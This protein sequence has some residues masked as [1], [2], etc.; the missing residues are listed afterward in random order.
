M[1]GF[2][3]VCSLMI[4]LLNVIY[5]LPPPS[6]EGGS[7]LAVV[8]DVTGSMYDDLQQVVEG[9]SRILEKTLSSRE[10]AIHNLALVPFHDPEVGPVM[11]T[12][13]PKEFQKEL[14]ELYVQ[15]GGD[16]P[17]MSITAIKLAMEVS[18]P[19]SFIYVFTDA[20][21]KDYKLT[22]DVLQ[23][24]Q[25]KQSQVVFVLTG[26]CG[27]RTHAGYKAY[28]EIAA[29]SSGQIFHL[30]KQQVDE[31][32]KWVEQAVQ[33]SKVHLL[34]TDHE[35]GGEH[36][37]KVPF[38]PSLKEVTISLSGL[39]P[40]IEV[41]DPSGQ[42]VLTGQG[43]NN[44]LDLPNSAKVVN[45]KKPM[46]GLW[47]IKLKSSGRHS[48]RITGVSSLDFR[49]G[50]ATKDTTDFSKTSRRPVQGA[51]VF[52]L[53]NCTGLKPPGQIQLVEFISTSGQSLKSMSVNSSSLTTSSH[54]WS[55]S[56][57][58]PPRENFFLKV[59]GND[60]LGYAF[61]RLSSVSYS[62]ISPRPP[63]VTMPRKIQGFYL[64][65]LTVFCS[66]DSDIAYTLRIL[67][68]GKRLEQDRI[69]D[70]S[71]NATWEIPEAA[72]VDEGLYECVAVSSAGTGQAYTYVAITE[73]P[74]SMGP[75]QNITAL[76]HERIILSCPVR[77]TVRY[78]MTWLHEGKELPANSERVRVS[79]DLSLEIIRVQPQD[80]GQYVCIASNHHGSSRSSIWL[81]I[82]EAPR[83]FVSPIS[84]SFV[85]GADVT[86]TCSA[87]GYPVPQI[88]W[89]FENAFFLRSYRHPV[90]EQGTL[91]I[92]NAAKEDAGRYTCIASNSG[93]ADRQSSTL[94]YTEPPVITVAKQNVLVAAGDE[95]I[96][97]C[98][99]SGIP[100][101]VVRWYK[102]KELVRYGEF[103]THQSTLQFRETQPKDTGRYTCV[104]SNEAGNSSAVIILDIGRAP[105]FSKVPS[106][107]S[108]DIG[109]SIALTCAADGLPP[110]KITWHKQD[111]KPVF[112][113]DGSL[114]S[115]KQLQS[116]NLFIKNVWAHDDGVF[117]CEAQNQFGTIQA[118][119]RVTV[120]NLVVPII[121]ASAS[122]VNV[123]EGQSFTLLCT[124]LAGNPPPSQRWSKDGTPLASNSRMTVQRDGSFHIA[125]ALPKDAGNYV[126]D[127]TSIAGSSNKSITVHVLVLPTIYTGPSHFTT[128]E[129][130]DVTLPCDSIGFPEPSVVWSKGRKA[131][132]SGSANYYITAAGSLVI[133]APSLED[134]GVYVCRA[135]NAA[136]FASQ[137][138][139]LSIYTK[140]RIGGST[141]EMVNSPL[142]IIAAAGT[143]VI[144]PC[145]AEGSPSPLMSWTKDS[146]PLLLRSA[147]YNLLP[148][149]SLIISE[150]R[151][152]DN[153]VYTCFAENPAGNASV[154]YYLKV[155]VSPKIRPYPK[156]LKALVGQTINLPC[157]AYGD[158]VPK[159]KWY[160]DDEPLHT[161]QELSQEGPDGTVKIA[162]VQLSD[163][164][165]Y[166]CVATNGAGRDASDI[167]LQVLEPPVFE[168]SD[169][170]VLEQKAHEKVILNCVIRG[171]P[172][173][174]IQWI[175]NGLELSGNEAGIA[176]LENGSLLIGLVS[177]SDAGDYVCRATNEA[178]SAQKKYR[179]KVLAPPEIKD[180]G[181]P[182]NISV[183][184]HLPL[185]LGCYATG[186]PSP[187]ITW[188][189]N[190][191]PVS[192]AQG[193]QILNEGTTLNI[194]RVQTED[195][196]TYSCKAVN[197]LGEDERH[198][199]V[200]VAVPPTIHGFGRLQEISAALG[201]QVELRCQAT[202]IPPPFIEWIKDGKAVSKLDSNLEFPNNG[203]VMKI[204]SSHPGDQGMYQCLAVNQA[205]QRALSFRVTINAQPTIR[206]SNQTTELSVLLNE[207]AKLHCDVQGAPV[208][209][210][211]WLKD[212]LPL[213][214]NFKTTYLEKGQILQISKSQIS[215][216]GI[217]TCRAS[218]SIGTAEKKFKLNVYVPPNMEE[219]KDALKKVRVT[220]GQS[221]VL[222]CSP[223]GHPP[224]VLSWHKNGL[225]LLPSEHLQI[226]SDG[227]IL[228]ID[229]ASESD[230][231]SYMCLASSTAGEQELEYSVEIQVPPQVLT[232]KED[233]FVT[234][235]VHSSL[236]LTCHAVGH[237]PP[238]IKWF[239]NS[240]PIEIHTDMWTSA[241]G[242]IL[243]IN[244]VKNDHAGEYMCTASNE[245]GDASGEFSVLVQEPPS[246]TVV[247]D[248]TVFALLGFPVTLQCSSTGLPPPTFTW[249]KDDILLSASG[250]SL[251]IKK[252]SLSDEGNYSCIAT[253]AAGEDRQEVVLAILVPPNIEPTD[254]N[255]TV[256]ERHT[257]LFECLASGTP[258]PEISWYKGS[259]LLSVGPRI[260]FFKGGRQLTINDVQ[261]S[262]AGSYRCVASST[263]GR[264]ELW[265][266]LQVNV[267]P[268]VEVLQNSV[269]VLV[270]QP[271]LLECDATGVP[272]PT[273]TWL[274]DGIPISTV[275][276]GLQV[277]SNGWTLSIEKARISDSG[278]YSCIASNTEGEDSQDITLHVQLSPSILG[279]E[280]NV[281]AL[282]NTSLT[283]ECQSHAIPPPTLQWLK[284]GHPLVLRKGV[285]ITQDGSLL[286]IE[287]AQVKDAGR[288]TC[289][290]R[291]N[292]GQTEKHFNLN[293]WVAPFSSSSTN[294]ITLTV[295]EGHIANLACEF[296]GIPSPSLTWK[297]DGVP[298]SGNNT[299]RVL[300]LSGG[301]LL[302]IL[303][304]QATDKGSYTC[305]GTNIVG[306]NHIDYTLEVHVLPRI[307]NGSKWP[308]DISANKG[309]TM[310]LECKTTGIPQPVVTWLKD[311]RPLPA[312]QRFSIQNAG[313]LLQ[314]RQADVHDAGRYTCRAL[315]VAG[316]AEKKFDLTIQVP[317]FLTGVS[318]APE[319]VTALLH[320]PLTL[321]CEATGNPPPIINWFRN[322]SPIRPSE[323]LQLLSGGRWLKLTHVRNHDDGNYTCVASSA[324]GKVE[325]NFMVD[326][327]VPPSI[328]GE[329]E[330][331]N[332]KVKAE[333]SINLT[334]RTIG[335]PKP[336]ITWLKD[337][338]VLVDQG[339]HHLSSD[340]S[341]LHITNA[342]LF[343]SGHYTCM[344]SN[345]IADRT[346]HY[347]INVLVS[348]T[349]PG[350]TQ[351]D[352]TEDVV[353]I[354]NNPTSLI[355]EALAYPPPTVTWLKD[356]SPFLASRNIR[357][358]PGGRGLQIL[359]AQEEDAG[360]YT[361]IVTNVAGEAVKNYEVKVFIPPQIL[362]GDQLLDSFGAREVK[363]KI[364]STL[365]LQCDSRAVPAPTLRWYKDGLLLEDNVHLQIEDEGKILKIKHT[366]ITDTG[367]YTC[368]A[369]NVAGEDEKDFDVN[370][371]VPPVFQKINGGHAAWEAAYRE[372][373]Y[374]DI[375]ERREV[376]TGDSVSLYCDS[377]AIPPPKLTW[378]KD[379][380]PLSAASEGVLILPGGRLLQIASVRPEDSGTYTC[381]AVNEV[382]ENNL[383]Y[384]L[385]VL[386]IPV[387]HGDKDFAEEVVVTVNS[388]AQLHCK[389]VGNPEPVIS[390]LK[391][392][393]PLN[394]SHRH[395]ILNG[396][397]TLEILAVHLP[398]VAGYVCVAENRAGSTEKLFTLT[399]QVPPRIIGEK[400]EQASVIVKNVVSLTCD[401]YSYPPPEITWFKG[402]RPFQPSVDSHFLNGGQVLQISQAK[403]TDAGEYVCVVTNPAGK[404]EKHIHLNVYAPPT[405]KE[406]SDKR[407]EVIVM[408]KGETVELHCE[409]DAVPE[410]TISWYK[411]G[412]QVVTVSEARTLSSGQMLKIQDIQMSDGGLYVCKITNIAGQAEQAFQLK[413]HDPPTFEDFN[414]EPVIPS[415]GG[416]VTLSCEATGIPTPVITWM[417][418][419]K[420][421]DNTMGW[422]LVSG[423]SRLHTS[424]LKVTDDGT[425]T[426]VAKNSEGEAHKSYI[427]TVQ[428]APR[429][430]AHTTEYRVVLGYSIALHCEAE[431]H[432]KPK[433]TWHKDGRPVPE[434]WR[435]RILENGTLWISQTKSN[436]AGRY[437]CKAGNAVGTFSQEM[438][439]IINVLPVI[440]T[441]QTELSVIKGFQAVLPCTAQGLPEPKVSWD[442]DGAPLQD[443]IGKF[444]VLP[445]G[446]MILENVMPEDS[447]NYTCTAVNAAGKARHSIY[448]TIQVPPT[449]TEVPGDMSLNKGERLV[450]TCAAKGNPL[451]VISW[452]FNNRQVAGISEKEGRSTL[453]VKEI[454]KSNAG[455]YVCTAEN[456]VGLI[457]AIGFVNIK[458]A[459][460]LRGELNSYQME[461]LG[462][463][464]VL[465]CEVHGDPKP[466]IHWNRNSRP[467]PVNSHMRQLSNG[468]LIIYGTENSD[469][470]EY[471][472][473]AENEVG[474]VEK[475]VT[476]MLQ[477]APYFTVKPVDTIVSAGGHVSLHCQAAGEPSP[478]VEW[479]WEGKPLH[480]SDRVTIL[481]NATL[482]I[483]AVEID[484][485][486]KY[487]CV[488]RNLMGSSFMGITL[489]VQGI[490]M[491]AKGS[492]IGNIN[493]QEFGI[494]YLS[495]NITEDAE[496]GIAK[497]EGTFQ[498]IPPSVGPLL[499]VL[500]AV[501]TPLYWSMAYQNSNTLNGFS[502]T[503]GIFRQESQIEFSTGEVL[504]ITHISRGLDA[505]GTLLSDT[506]INGFVPKSLTNA[507]VPLKEFSERYVQTGPGQLYAWSSQNFL[508]DGFLVPFQC[509][510]TVTYNTSLGR[511][512]MLVQ[513][514]KVSSL[515]IYYSIINKEVT[516][517]MASSMETDIM[518]DQCPQGFVKDM[519]SYCAD[520]NECALLNPCSHECLNKMGGFNCAC[521]RGYDLASNGRNCTDINE[522][523]QGTH[524]CHQGQQCD[525]LVGSYRCL[526]SCRVGF[527]NTADG[528]GCEDVDE[529][530]DG[531]HLCRYNQRCENTVAGYHCSCPRG[532]RSQGLARPC[533]DIN[534]CQK[535]PSPCAYQCR[536]LPGSYR[537]L[538][539]PG[540]ILLGDG[541]SC[542]GIEKP[543][544]NVSHVHGGFRPQL[545]STHFSQ[546]GQTQTNTLLTWHPFSK[547]GNIVG[548]VNRQP[549]PPG[550][551]RQNSICTD[552]DECQVRNPCQHECR[553]TQGSYQCSCPPGYRLLPNGRNCRDVDECMEQNIQCGANQ[554]CFNTRGSFQCIDTPCPA[555]YRKGANPGVC[556]KRCVLDC[557]TGGPYTLQYK[558]FTL[559]H[560]IPANHD[561]IRLTAFSDRGILQ[562][563]TTFTVLERAADSP[564][565]IRTENG[566]GIIYTQR[567][568]LDS[569]V[570]RMKVQAVSY[571]EQGKIK[572]QSAFII[573]I[574]VSSYP[575]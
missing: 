258:L 355:C 554:M 98:F 132:S 85:T 254:V 179:M 261:I 495:A 153:G 299:S 292:A 226:L 81:F 395:R 333:Q 184:I 319:I 286:Q 31:V 550:F 490:S 419:G 296:D 287:R 56:D 351:D 301:R 102:G 366:K 72:G 316:Q 24:I 7:T 234:A 420:P 558:L 324:A 363:L 377:N 396:G 105:A 83:A 535:I 237:P 101:P 383:H 370:I 162:P 529:C 293:I 86:I 349:I 471:R 379:N 92:K 235:I 511:Q 332:L 290:A 131:I 568:L 150:T 566:R 41:R 537:C 58:V 520:E 167:T 77:G 453:E 504:R 219:S 548:Q 21:A 413:V 522:C 8:F 375:I 331:E 60:R 164:G 13:D 432:P 273:V 280:Q 307:E 515:S 416:P 45:T 362:K 456:R 380:K 560:G 438:M 343:Y 401:A 341:V 130:V 140:P 294:I 147:R 514:L 339:S 532:Y 38:D 407:Q 335:N 275:T 127:V 306:T 372:N 308:T 28:E 19:G 37:W 216:A 276:N 364:N 546:S 264:T 168:D 358:L 348:P 429:I 492:L 30:D 220:A 510:H 112:S 157:V 89:E 516:F 467:L 357:I 57:F 338:S 424:Q 282:V 210:I 114:S 172:P 256:R 361:C 367:R 215:D 100:H 44:L 562:N 417:K 303:K 129:G 62:S 527:R 107:V 444:T 16:C 385:S 563:Q 139:H 51:S 233:G 278:T 425:Y 390:W 204:I 352:A 163:A 573:F 384:E 312:R 55:V 553:N 169:D 217:Y 446:D 309:A 160:K 310:M 265:Y 340:S 11:I 43:L 423:G 329:D 386:S 400:S 91:T 155:Q 3:R 177:S 551:I 76:L 54:L 472:C 202:G 392:G 253:N 337:G 344:A 249:M 159:F 257:A 445:S 242:R 382:G 59:T 240:Q 34:S 243:T 462:G 146:R 500:V 230:A 277:L 455:T 478:A 225:R 443:I 322:G 79:P 17:E 5:C 489:T 538:C 291:N 111:G 368:I 575:Y 268:V 27:S 393:L 488:A 410:P 482:R 143:E 12:E 228:K 99:A 69:Y 73:P 203:Q 53:L 197:K 33:A 479:T 63:I 213:A 317:P 463:N 415:L 440:S 439:L 109:G 557:S 123:L 318:D 359:N 547:N 70:E 176:V 208:P 260:S 262:D 88:I 93:G 391:D 521:P 188:Y 503:R 46:P 270:S 239:K 6:G 524:M 178:G 497:I 283:L 365:T 22:Q 104:A 536:N 541:K 468:S 437:V 404:D 330:V 314:I 29:T 328:E 499:R 125:E 448:L 49:A 196:G 252:A 460:V 496:S 185:T 561:V 397:Q 342:T 398:D 180:D 65:P 378:Y 387:I 493:E 447:G 47:T 466:I 78:N 336:K 113:S 427:L 464:A 526:V 315:N 477:S 244:P 175:R 274:K 408:R 32:L 487:E 458:E 545:V 327:W 491:K 430:K 154:S 347:Q 465:N 450:L 149:G 555:S 74:P 461:P 136:G 165:K 556:Y 152:K 574:A 304:V 549:C 269:I 52:M 166:V 248:K 399:V 224:P 4:S 285:G 389:A 409:S 374:H 158:P 2:L 281:S 108:V 48:V 118:E 457:K 552:L 187:A 373:D 191:Q 509:N 302:Q 141:P 272:V 94:L 459:P 422:R 353:V 323:E 137:E 311:G 75:S 1:S 451:P 334:C 473:V 533:L 406:Q 388:T 528:T 42:L 517:T 345:S 229:Q 170:T 236:E 241:D 405:V 142:E 475:K 25:L 531:T 119:A 193:L 138:V 9:A 214:S 498:N 544:V 209:R 486:G 106:D 255:L 190:G 67:K 207:H 569:R 435:M 35:D 513:L 507:A 271:V 82:L 570:H 428:A 346:K 525:N 251:Q 325:K 402:G 421:I 198:F 206:G 518:G 18:L 469:A 320:S 476:L 485:M 205:G 250:N 23:M 483:A 403:L 454:S 15:G 279:E 452:T 484:D 508:Q 321:M 436:D 145:E 133:T 110:P 381:K 572:Y 267:L 433:V 506:V 194:Y 121:A 540:Q 128:N 211:S 305:E 115:A 117:I 232:G 289:E 442:K 174:V 221:L 64:Q 103:G 542:A 449:F 414:E 530:Q 481:P 297:K 501:F 523:V 534:E 441:T 134:S 284:D 259:H 227:K 354:L 71:I 148:S 192:R 84:Q 66:V 371:Q 231:G 189:K 222:K 356:G 90:N 50:F 543:A 474:V 288:Y 126:C 571:E 182:Q 300:V 116:D 480:E 246:V 151:L 326:V 96:L 87:S 245:A 431:G 223:T 156:I 144:L 195:S 97:K 199:D 186:I 564:F 120:T 434:N 247:G 266:S 10:K 61:Q 218:N 68:D 26:D 238:E 505:E 183:L 350:V 369:T 559:P 263:V 181:Q 40:V 122:T 20:R 171:T 426:C 124:V 14:R 36:T 411:N 394:T 494:A 470:G 519:N 200:L 80:S 412:H 539:P 161:A 212:S 95:A 201:S 512:S 360:R 173:P 567:Q 502:M 376:T 295:T 39:A 565:A 298:L 135:T 313:Q 418:D